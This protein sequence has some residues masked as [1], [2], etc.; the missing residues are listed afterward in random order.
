[1][2]A[3]ACGVPVITTR[4][5]AIGEIVEQG[6]TGLIVESRSAPALAA[7]LARLKDDSA[8][9]LRLGAAGLAQARER[10]SMERMLDAME[11]VFESVMEH[12]PS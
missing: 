12:A 6:R 10:F 7:A 5:G 3:M 9:R 4:A 2:Q 8:M 1:M 11:A